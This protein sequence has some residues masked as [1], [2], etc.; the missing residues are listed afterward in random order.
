MRNEA[1]MICP[2]VLGGLSIPR[3]PCEIK[4]WEK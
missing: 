3:S 2:E 4:R 1:I